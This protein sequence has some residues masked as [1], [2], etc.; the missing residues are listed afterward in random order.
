MYLVPIIDVSTRWNSTFDMLLRAVEYKDIIS[1]TFYRHRDNAFINLLLDENDWSCV[2][3]LVELLRPL[4]E[5]T[6][7]VSQGGEALTISN[8]IPL[9]HYCTETLKQCLQKFNSNDDIYS[10]IE[11][12]IEKL[13]YYYDKISPMAGIAIILD[14]RMKKDFLKDILGWKEDWVNSVESHFSESYQFYKSKVTV[15]H[16][17]PHSTTGTL[18]APAHFLERLKRRR[19][20][21]SNTTIEEE[22]VR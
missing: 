18:S 3:Q 5:V 15:A 12:G 8:V 16:S 1:E 19:V 11:A 14:P 22:F 9:F 4:K 10:G 2:S 13:E 7:L 17:I 20:D 6:L 21:V